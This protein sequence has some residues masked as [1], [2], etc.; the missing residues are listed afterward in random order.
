MNYK[1]RNINYKE[2]RKT[3]YREKRKRNYN[4]NRRQKKLKRNKIIM[5]TVIYVIMISHNNISMK[6]KK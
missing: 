3:Y 2:K 1:K 5:V 6:V 4:K